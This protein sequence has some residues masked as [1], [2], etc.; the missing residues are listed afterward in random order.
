MLKKTVVIVGAVVFIASLLSPANAAWKNITKYDGVGSGSGWYG[1]Q[2]DQEVE[3]NCVASQP[4]DLEAFYFDAATSKLNLTGGYNFKNGYDGWY[5]GDIFID[6]TGDAGNPGGYVQPSNGIFDV[7]N[8]RFGYEY[9]VRLNKTGNNLNLTYDVIDLT[10]GGPVTVKT[11]YY[12][13]NAKSNPWTYVSG[14]NVIQTGKTLGFQGGLT[15]AAASLEGATLLGGNHY[16]ISGIDLS[17]LGG[18]TFTAHYTMGCG[19]DNILGSATVNVPEP[20][21]VSLLIL[22][23]VLL[24]GLLYLNRK[25]KVTA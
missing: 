10:Q 5:S 25:K 15:D 19:N 4:W 12:K 23:V 6:V 16:S 1:A 9:V 20:S 13:Q 18:K 24:G 14:G 2:E 22:G 3:P 8:N 7:Q 11:S 17:F 21:S